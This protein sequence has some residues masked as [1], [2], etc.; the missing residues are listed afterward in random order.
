MVISIDIGNSRY[1]QIANQKRANN[2]YTD[3]LSMYTN[4]FFL[5]KITDM[6]LIRALPM[7]Y[8]RIVNGC[9]LTK[10]DL[11]TDGIATIALPTN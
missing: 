3:R 9:F 1:W 2:F 11:Y 8:L 4:S 6:I 10:F 7:D 5:R